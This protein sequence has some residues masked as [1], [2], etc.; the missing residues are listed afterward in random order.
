M[1]SLK[2]VKI[3]LFSLITYFNLPPLTQ[4]LLRQI[5]IFKIAVFET[6]STIFPHVISQYA[7]YFY[8]TWMVFSFSQTLSS[9]SHNFSIESFGVLHKYFVVAGKEGI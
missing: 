4:V 2:T 8:F 7:R 1:D 9:S 6:P 5:N 3:N